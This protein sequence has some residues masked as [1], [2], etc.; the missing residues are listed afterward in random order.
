VPRRDTSMGETEIDA[1]LA[2]SHH[3]QVATLGRDGFPHLTTLWFCVLDGLVTFRS[4]TKSQRI[5]NLLRDDRITVLVEEGDDYA[6]LRGVMVKG[7]ARL[8]ADPDL[9]MRVYAEVTRKRQGLAT[10]DPAA[11]EAM[12][13]RFKTK[14]TVVTVDPVEVISWDHRKLTGY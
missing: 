1:M 5:V 7:R 3:L 10:I 2:T 8:S 14:N 11:V 13:G 12:F 9:V 6:D 4:F